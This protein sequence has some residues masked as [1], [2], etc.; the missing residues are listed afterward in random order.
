MVS[1][2]LLLVPH[3]P[4]PDRKRHIYVR[5][6]VKASFTL[7]DVDHANTVHELIEVLCC[8]VETVTSSV[9]QLP[10]IIPPNRQRAF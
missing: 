6:M 4:L 10:L 1:D 2:T 5:W 8:P 9:Q 3:F 7:W